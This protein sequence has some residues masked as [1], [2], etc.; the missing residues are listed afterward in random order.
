MKTNKILG[1]FLFS[2]LLFSTA[3]V[4]TQEV[5]ESYIYNWQIYKPQN[6]SVYCCGS[7]CDNRYCCDDLKYR[8]DQ[9]LCIQENCTGYYQYWYYLPP[10]DCFHKFCCGYCHQRYCCTSPGSR[11]NQSECSTEKPVTKIEIST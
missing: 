11:L 7:S 1:L 10:V 8:L 6:C 9:N 3:K 4:E 2:F 5:C